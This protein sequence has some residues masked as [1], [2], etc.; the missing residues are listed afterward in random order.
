MTNCYLVGQ[1]FAGRHSMANAD[2]Y[3]DWAA[4]IRK[5]AAECKFEDVR[6]RLIEAAKGFDDLGSAAESRVVEPLSLLLPRLLSQSAPE[7]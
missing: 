6:A 1:T 5:Q 7:A 3:H 4:E 2:H